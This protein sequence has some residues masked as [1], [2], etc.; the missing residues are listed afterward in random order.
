M[1]QMPRRSPRLTHFAYVAVALL[2]SGCGQGSSTSATTDDEVAALSAPQFAQPIML[3][4]SGDTFAQAQAA[5]AMQGNSPIYSAD[6]HVVGI[7]LLP[8][9]GSDDNHIY[10]TTYAFS[11]FIDSYTFPRDAIEHWLIRKNILQIQRYSI[12][13]SMPA[14][15]YYGKITTFECP[16]LT[17]GLRQYLPANQNGADIHGGLVIPL[18][19]RKFVAWTYRNR[20]ETQMPNAGTVKVFAG[21][22]TYTLESTIQGATPSGTGT[23]S[24]KAILNPDTGK[25][26]SDSYQGQDPSLT[27]Q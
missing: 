3:H 9:H 6:S 19:T 27:L 12:R 17:E 24:V 21:T 22:F 5:S 13:H 11:A 25:W 10:P 7:N 23:A 2:L 26:Q 14:D 1:P 16:V 20:Y 18:L 4:L 15:F 8:C